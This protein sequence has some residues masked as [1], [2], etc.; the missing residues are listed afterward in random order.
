MIAPEQLAV[1]LDDALDVE[2]RDAIENELERDAEALQFV[3]EQRKID[4]ALRSILGIATHKQR[5]KKSILAGVAGASVEQLRGQVP[6]DTS[7]RKNRPAMVASQ[8]TA[9]MTPAQNNG[10]SGCERTGLWRTF[11]TWTAVARQCLNSSVVGRFAAAA[12]AV[13]V[14]G[15][16]SY[17]FTVGRKPVP[18]A[19]VGELAVVIGTP[20]LRRE[21]ER[22]AT[23]ATRATPVRFGDRIET[24][25][26]DKAEIQF[27]RRHH[28]AAPLQH[29]TGNSKSEIRKFQSA[30]GNWQSAPGDL[31]PRPSDASTTAQSQ[32]PARAGVDQSAEGHQRA[33]VRR[34]D[35]GRHCDRA[36][37]G[38]R[39]K[40][41]EGR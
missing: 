20:S 25:D 15:V 8:A 21:G 38:V 2:S 10:V 7:G 4:R 28:V 39:T 14:L 35:P 24:G 12:A 33:A 32:S 29:R 27:R 19:Q 5:L 22:V 3:I 16:G 17:L 11:R 13:V 1:F 26:A 36:G 41:S 40:G 9:A 34:A 6:A 31:T 23:E 30:I 18:Q 37:N